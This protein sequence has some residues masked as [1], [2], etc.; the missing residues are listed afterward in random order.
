MPHGRERLSTAEAGPASSG[1]AGR[2]RSPARARPAAAPP[3][4]PTPTTSAAP[5]VPAAPARRDTEA[6]RAAILW[7]AR[8]LP[9]RH[10]HADTTLKAVAE[11]AGASPPLIL[12]HFG[13]K[14]ALLARVM[15]FET[16]ATALLGIGAVHGLAG[17]PMCVPPPST[18]SWTGTRPPCRPLSPPGR[19]GRAG[20]RCRSHARPRRMTD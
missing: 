10:A 13:N 18:S 1:T 17:A 8:H 3:H 14:D 12:K 19:P 16:D 7:A 20:R 15:S 2:P 11:R 9:A 5:P 6:G 4:P